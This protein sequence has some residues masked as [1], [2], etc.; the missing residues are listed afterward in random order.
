MI[1]IV[2]LLCKWCFVKNYIFFKL[3]FYCV[4]LVNT[5]LCTHYVNMYSIYQKNNVYR[6]YQNHVSISSLISVLSTHF[7]F[8]RFIFYM[9]LSRL[10]SDEW[11]FLW[12][13][14]ANRQLNHIPSLRQISR[15][16]NMLNLF[17]LSQLLTR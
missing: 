13:N 5:F 14:S 3:P 15:C 1:L 10:Y 9:S 7:V 2:D 12:L 4:I 16:A 6:V 11:P 8:K 17:L